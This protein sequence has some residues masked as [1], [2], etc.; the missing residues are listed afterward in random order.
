MATQTRDFCDVQFDI[1]NNSLLWQV[2]MVALCKK[3]EF[4]YAVA[5]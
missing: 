2:P 1:M 3:F 4:G 5:F